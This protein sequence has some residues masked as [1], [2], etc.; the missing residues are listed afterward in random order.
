MSERSPSTV[1][2]VASISITVF[3]ISLGY[4][5][6]IQLTGGNQLGKCELKQGV[7]PKLV[8]NAKRPKVPNNVFVDSHQNDKRVSDYLGRGLVVNF[9]A[10]WCTPCVKEM[11][12]L[13]RLRSAV[14]PFNIDVLAISEDKNAVDVVGSFYA[15]HQL[16]NLDILIDQEKKF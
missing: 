11:P 13:D 4:L 14:K 12:H 10:T 16:K 1:K 5:L 15:F 2:T 3:L 6:Y 8:L 9:W 7:L